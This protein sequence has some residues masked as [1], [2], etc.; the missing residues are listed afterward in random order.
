MKF[1]ISM[2]ELRSRFELLSPED[3]KKAYKVLSAVGIDLSK[4][5]DDL[6]GTR[7]S[8]FILENRFY[9]A[10]SHKSVFL[11]V[12]EIVLKKHPNDQDKIFKIQGTK[13][14][15]F[16]KN[17]GEFTHDYEIIRGTRI[18][19]DTNENAAQLNRRCQKILLL[20]GIDP[21]SLMVIPT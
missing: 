8:G 12:A 9:E 11:Q 17:F 20:F 16:S 6:T 10:D 2:D 15:Y 18:Y 3:K 19:A 14:K 4:R 13:K 21:S 1:D 7:V 5:K